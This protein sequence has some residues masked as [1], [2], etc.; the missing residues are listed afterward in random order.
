LACASN[1]RTT[2]KFLKLPRPDAHDVT[3]LILTWKGGRTQRQ[4]RSATGEVVEYSAGDSLQSYIKRL[5]RAAGLFDAS[6]GRRTFASRL[7]AG[8]Q[9]LEDVLHAA[10][11]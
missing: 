1:E 4:T 8:G 9:S 7:L 11:R 2:D 10:R 5:Y 6:S 3:R